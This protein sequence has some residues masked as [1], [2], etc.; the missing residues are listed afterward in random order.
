MEQEWF[1]GGSRVR[2]PCMRTLLAAKATLAAAEE[3]LWLTARIA[4][5]QGED[6]ED[7]AAI[8]LRDGASRSALY[9]QLR[10]RGL[11]YGRGA[12]AREEP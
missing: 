10:K 9:A 3:T 5:D 8:V 6:P 7:V 4:L 2:V 1:D 11:T 12:V